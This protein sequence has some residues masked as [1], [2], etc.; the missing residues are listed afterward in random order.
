[1]GRERVGSL[2]GERGWEAESLCILF[3]GPA[4]ASKE[5]AAGAMTSPPRAGRAPAFERLAW[6]VLRPSVLSN[7]AQER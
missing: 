5:H 2:T 3:P 4:M 7:A 6:A 1:M